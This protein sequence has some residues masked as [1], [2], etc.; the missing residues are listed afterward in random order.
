[1]ANFSAEAYSA[2]DWVDLFDAAGA[3]YFVQVAKHHDGFALFDVPANV[4]K[5]TSVALRPHRNFIE[6]LFTAAEKYQPRLH[7]ATYYS[8]PEWFHPDYRPY[9]FGRW[10][11]GNATNPFTN[12]TLPYTGYVPVN[13]YLG[14]FVLPQ[15]QALAS[16][17]TEIMW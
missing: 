10:P 3:K 11:G 7:R 17:G 6:E 4:T 12:Q 15:M 16:L 14:D 8:L 9:G 2:K 1:M 13:D 5:R